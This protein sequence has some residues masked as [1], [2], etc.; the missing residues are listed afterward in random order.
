M[1]YI[2][3]N[4]IS[5]PYSF[6]FRRLCHCS[7]SLVL[8]HLSL[9]QFLAVFYIRDRRCFMHRISVPYWDVHWIDESLVILT[10]VTPG[11]ASA[12]R[13]IGYN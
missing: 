7:D 11:L 12:D 13:I 10:D 4:F 6:A 3:F 5:P 2:K 8:I 9:V 1:T